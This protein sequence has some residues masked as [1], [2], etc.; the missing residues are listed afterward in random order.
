MLA[1]TWRKNDIPPLLLRLQAGTTTLKSSLVFPQK[2]G[3]SNLNTAIPLHGIYSE[4]V[5]ACNKDTC[6]TMFIA[7]I[8]ITARPEK[9]PDVLQ[10]DT[11][12]M[13][14]LPNEV[15]LSY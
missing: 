1:R 13:V 14:H 8:F 3:H 10:Q 5:P 12:N 15:L 6:S 9:N 2:I 7:A 11:E 4:Y